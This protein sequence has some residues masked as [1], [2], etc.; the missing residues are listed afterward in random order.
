MSCGNDGT[1]QV[2]PGFRV[3]VPKASSVVEVRVSI[4]SSIIGYWVEPCVNRAFFVQEVSIARYN[5]KHAT[6]HL[7]LRDRASI[8]S[9]EASKGQNRKTG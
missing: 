2:F 4:D 5:G 1:S 3:D 8:F 9:L 6:H 7:S